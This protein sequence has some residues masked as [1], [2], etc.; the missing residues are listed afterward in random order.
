M[1]TPWESALE[2]VGAG[3]TASVVAGRAIWRWL[4]NSVAEA[5]DQ[6][7]KEMTP[8]GSDTTTGETLADIRDLL[9][10]IA[11]QQGGQPEQQQRRQPRNF[12]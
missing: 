1:A 6:L 4:V 11:G 8:P 7:R 10:Q 5:V 9:R 3:I 2:G 12:H